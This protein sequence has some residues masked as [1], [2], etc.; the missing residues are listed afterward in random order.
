MPVVIGARIVQGNLNKEILFRACAAQKLACVQRPALGDIADP[1][2][3]RPSQTL[4]QI[5]QARCIVDSIPKQRPRLAVGRK[6]FTTCRDLQQ[7]HGQIFDLVP[8]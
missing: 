5:G 4:K 7:G 3:D 6:Q 8:R 2:N 1:F